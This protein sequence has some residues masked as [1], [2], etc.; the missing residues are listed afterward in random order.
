MGFSVLI[1]DDSEP[2]LEAARALLERQ[3]LEVLEVASTSA[4]ALGRVGE[5]R[6]DIVLVDINLGPESGFELAR[7]LDG[8]GSRPTVILMSTGTEADFGELIG[9]STASGFLTKSELSADGIRT[10]AEQ[11]PR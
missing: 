11:R 10:I 4:Q 9:D 3:G 8:H 7:Q 6:P 2:F 5:L 1:V